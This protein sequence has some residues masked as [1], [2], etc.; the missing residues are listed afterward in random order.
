MMD[1][2]IP[3]G[4]HRPAAVPPSLPD[5]VHCRRPEGVGVAHDGSDVEVVLPVLDCYMEGMPAPVEIGDDC[6]MSPIPIS[7]DHVALI[8]GFQ[9][10]RVIPRILW[11]RRGVWAYSYLSCSIVVGGHPAM[12]SADPPLA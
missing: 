5:D 4:D 9:Q 2:L 1:V 11:P 12:V 8:S 10:I 7:V 6:V 3:I